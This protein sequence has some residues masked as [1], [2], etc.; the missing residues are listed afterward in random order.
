MTHHHPE[1]QAWV[2]EPQAPPV[3]QRV[4]LETEGTLL[5]VQQSQTVMEP[6]PPGAQLPAHGSQEPLT[7]WAPGSS[8]HRGGRA[9]Q[10]QPLDSMLSGRADRP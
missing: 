8:T 3:L 1:G 9:V 10:G 4:A 6:N 5:T 2:R 7:R